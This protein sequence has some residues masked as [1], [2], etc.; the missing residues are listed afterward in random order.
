MNFRQ[1]MGR[2]ILSCAILLFGCRDSTH[3][4]RL[5]LE[6]IGSTTKTD[7]I[8]AYPIRGIFLLNLIHD[9]SFGRMSTNYAVAKRNKD[10][11]LILYRLDKTGEI[12]GRVS[13]QY[14]AFVNPVETLNWGWFEIQN[15][16]VAD[17]LPGMN[18]ILDSLR[19]SSSKQ[20]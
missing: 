5:K 3:V 19:T 17:E 4:L 1:I 7:T 2:S 9:Y 20:S 18:L 8:E 15:G 10:G 6:Q 13:N 12:E 11:R 16:K 14:I